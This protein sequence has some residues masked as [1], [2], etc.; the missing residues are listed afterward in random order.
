MATSILFLRLR[1]RLRPTWRPGR[2]KTPCLGRDNKPHM[3]S[4]RPRGSSIF[5]GLILLFIGV[6]LLLHNYRGF[7]L[8]DVVVHWWPLVLIFWGGIKLY[9]RTAGR[10]ILDPGAS[11]ITGGEVALVVGLLALVGIVVGVEQARQRIPGLVDIDLPEAFANSLDIAPKP[12]APNARITVR[13]GRGDVTVRA[14]DEP[15]IRVSGKVNVKS[16]SENAARRKG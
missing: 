14:A 15:E 9:E 11:R 2:R 4:P 16:W 1:L 7:E 6:L 10:R 8:S 12:V 5:S 13:E 3:A